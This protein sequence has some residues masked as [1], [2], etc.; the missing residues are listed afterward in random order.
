MYFI[1]CNKCGKQYAGSCKTKFRCRP[2]NYNSTHG[3]F[4]NKR[5]VP[6]EALKQNIFDEHFCLVYRNGTQD[7]IHKLDTFFPNGLN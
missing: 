7:W 1:K 2:N 5:Q 6:K 3:K 4:R